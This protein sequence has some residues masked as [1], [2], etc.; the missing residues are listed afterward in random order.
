MLTTT[1]VTAATT[2]DAVTTATPPSNF[3]ALDREEQT[4][5][6]VSCVW[7][8]V[9]EGNKVVGY[10]LLS[11]EDLQGKRYYYRFYSDFTMHEWADDTTVNKLYKWEWTQDNKL[12][13]TNY[14]DKTGQSASSWYFDATYLINENLNTQDFTP[15]G[16][17]STYPAEPPIIK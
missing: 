9:G 10:Y 15:H 6:L 7:Q 4:A 16:I 5:L 13:V 1:T 8:V 14:A 11:D 17:A 12:K 2:I 3:T